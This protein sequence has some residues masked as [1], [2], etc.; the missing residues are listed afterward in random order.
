[1]SERYK[2]AKEAWFVP[3]GPINGVDLIKLAALRSWREFTCAKYS[4]GTLLRKLENKF[5]GSNQATSQIDPPRDGCTYWLRGDRNSEN[6]DQP[7]TVFVVRDGAII[8][9]RAVNRQ[10]WEVMP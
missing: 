7:G 9:I 1:M 10:D 3:F 8:S 5:E 4:H 2:I 6:S